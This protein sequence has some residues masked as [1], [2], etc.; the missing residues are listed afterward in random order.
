M[1]SQKQCILS[2]T[3]NRPATSKIQHSVEFSGCKT[4][5]VPYHQLDTLSSANVLMYSSLGLTAQILQTPLLISS[6]VPNVNFVAT[7]FE[8][9]RSTHEG[10][11]RTKK[12]K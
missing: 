3:Q 7:R 8:S 1:Y 11:E 4:V 12:R 9:T 10:D 6:Q 2:G 5:N